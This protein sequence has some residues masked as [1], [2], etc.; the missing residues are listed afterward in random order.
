MKK[1][2]GIAFAEL[3]A[4]KLSESFWAGIQRMSA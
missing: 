3:K 1:L 4:Q 2:V